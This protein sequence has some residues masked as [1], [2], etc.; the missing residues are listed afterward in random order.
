[1]FVIAV[2]ASAILG[3]ILAWAM[4]KAERPDGKC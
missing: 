3:T 1:M 4:N 2:I